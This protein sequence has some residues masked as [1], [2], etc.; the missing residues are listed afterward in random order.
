MD[1]SHEV[2][3]AA[4]PK[5][6]RILDLEFRHVI[7]I[8]ST[9]MKTSRRSTSSTKKPAKKR[10]RTAFV[11]IGVNPTGRHPSP[12]LKAADSVFN[13]RIGNENALS[14]KIVNFNN[15]NKGT[16]SWNRLGRSA[17]MKYIHLRGIIYDTGTLPPNDYI[18][19]YILYADEDYPSTYSTMFNGYDYLGSA[20]ST[21]GNRTFLFNNLDKSLNYRVLFSKYIR[22][23]S[24]DELAD[25]SGKAYQIEAH[26][27][28][29]FPTVWD[30]VPFSTFD[31]AITSGSLLLGVQG[32]TQPIATS[33]LWFQG[34]VR[35]R[36]TDN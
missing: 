23:T 31:G 2:R 17:Q 11:G 9:H 22:V 34:G 32:T 28:C 6:D 13:L 4:D 12:E 26:I 29:D 14:S 10:Q 8:H 19:V 1:V 7:F 20:L 3:P 21:T 18:H 24:T 25:N 35:V 33:T 15:I 30:T 5:G 16:S 36:Y 27:P